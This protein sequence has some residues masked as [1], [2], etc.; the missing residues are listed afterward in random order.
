MTTDDEAN[1]RAWAVLHA[2][3]G[4]V[5][6]IISLRLLDELQRLRKEL[7]SRDRVAVPTRFGAGPVVN[8]DHS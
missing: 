1:L 8:D 4:M 7:E 6:A 2:K 3:I 5:Q